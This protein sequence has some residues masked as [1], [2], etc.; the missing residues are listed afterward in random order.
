[1]PYDKNRTTALI[2]MSKCY[3]GS[4]M[5]DW[6]FD[7]KN[8]RKFKSIVFA[9]NKMYYSKDDSL[10][11]SRLS[12]SNISE[13]RS[14]AYLT[15]DIDTYVL[16][17]PAKRA[18]SLQRAIK[19]FSCCQQETLQPL[20]CNSWALSEHT[21]KSR[22]TYAK[23]FEQF[24]DCEY[25]LETKRNLPEHFTVYRAGTKDDGGISWTLSRKTAVFFQE[26]YQLYL[27]EDRHILKKQVSRDDVVCFINCAGEKEVIILPKSKSMP[28]KQ[29]S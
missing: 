18:Y 19:K 2:E 25:F 1:M 24:K 14:W 26:R 29:L 6:I 5:V 10:I 3:V 22:K 20:I 17:D 4:K 23:I 8:R 9:P 16:A 11:V 7:S 28:K 13:L 12:K 21:L 27:N 15:G